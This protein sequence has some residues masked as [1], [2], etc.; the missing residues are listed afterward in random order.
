MIMIMP[1]CLTFLLLQLCVQTSDKGV[2]PKNKGLQIKED[3][4]FKKDVEITFNVEM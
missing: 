4:T 1:V 2:D 3:S